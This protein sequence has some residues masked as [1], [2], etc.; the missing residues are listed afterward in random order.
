MEILSELDD[1]A[2]VEQ[3]RSG[4]AAAFSELFRRHRDA[5]ARM[6]SER[7]TFASDVDDAVQ[8]SFARA[9]GRLN[10]LREPARFGPWVRSIA[11]RTCTDHHR[12]RRRVIVLGDA[13]VREV[14]DTRPGPYEAL[15]VR[16]RSAAFQARLFELAERDRR[17]LWMRHVADA[18]V[19]AVATELGLTE[20]STR[21]LLTRAR[22]RLR[23]A[24]AGLPVLVPLS[25][26]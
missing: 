16:E 17:A 21:V 7:L 9:L 13:G 23:A 8:E 15:E 22:H 5:V 10:Q 6:C 24:V 20:G 1:A 18:P 12:D 3:A 11:V 26:R 14:E 25:W 4:E 19:A 2:L